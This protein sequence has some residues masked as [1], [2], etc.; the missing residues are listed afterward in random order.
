MTHVSLMRLRCRI[1]T[2][3][4][5]RASAGDAMLLDRQ[6]T[7]TY[8]RFLARE[9]RRDYA[10]AH[11]LLRRTLTS[12]EPSR[13]PQE[14]SFARTP[15]G[16]PYLSE[17]NVNGSPVRFSLTHTRGYVAC[18]ISP[19]ADVGI[20]AECRSHIN[21]LDRLLAGVCS[22]AEQAQVG[23]APAPA[24]TALFL[25]LWAL[26]EAYL[27]ARGTGLDARLPNIGFDLRAPAMIL[28]SFRPDATTAWWFGLFRPSV[29]S[30]IAI[31]IAPARGT[32]L[33]LDAT[34]VRPDGLSTSM[35]PVRASGPFRL[36]AAATEA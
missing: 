9:D 15:H 19:D 31:A 14:W 22:P 28:A 17:A 11:A 1:T 30:R 5:D 33:M 13:S 8:Q 24:R 12:L 4:T 29:E 20:D 25:D 16:K 36:A 18:A 6:E 10:A 27:K 32:E 26:K 7:E 2:A 35:Q 34:I 3:L 23:A 21:E